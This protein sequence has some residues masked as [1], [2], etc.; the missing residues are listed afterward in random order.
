MSGLANCNVVNV[1]NGSWLDINTLWIGMQALRKS[2]DDGK[3]LGM[4]HGVL[5]NG[6]G[7]Y[8]YNDTLVPEGIDH[9]TIEV[10]PGNINTST[11]LVKRKIVFLLCLWFKMCFLFT[12]IALTCSDIILSLE[13][14]Q[15]FYLSIRCL[16]SQL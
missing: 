16:M 12:K 14:P 1:C 13:L 5:I 7:P 9:E 2:L 15:E 10:H 3:D 4:P 6:K 8:R 11:K